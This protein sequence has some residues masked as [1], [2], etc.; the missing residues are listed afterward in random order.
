MFQAVEYV[1]FDTSPELRRRVENTMGWLEDEV[2]IWRDQMRV[3][4]EVRFD[5]ESAAAVVLDLVLAQSE[6][7]T[8]ASEYIPILDLIDEGE[9]RSHCRRVWSRVLDN[10]LDHQRRRVAEYLEQPVEA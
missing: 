3:E 6:R 2:R 1:G 8:R 7:T 9:F 10:V 4:W 5:T